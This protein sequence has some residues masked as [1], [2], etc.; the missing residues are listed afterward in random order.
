MKPSVQEA[1]KERL[2]ERNCAYVSVESTDVS[3][4][5]RLRAIG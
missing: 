2:P 1:N 4:L 5:D 3:Y